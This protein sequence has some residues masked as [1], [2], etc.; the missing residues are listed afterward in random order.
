MIKV[1]IVDDHDLVRAGISSVLAAQD[2]ISVVGEACSGEEALRMCRELSPDVVLMDVRMPGIGGL[3]ATTK[4]AVQHPLIKV[5]IITVCED[6]LMP[7]R[8]LQA[9]ASG[10]ITKGAS[11]EEMVKAI[12]SVHRGDPYISGHLAQQMA[13]Q[14]LRPQTE[15]SPFEGL[16]D[17]EIQV[18]LM[19]TTG[20]KVSEI[21]EVLNLSPKTVNTYRYRIFEK[22]GASSDVELMRLAIRHGLVDA[23]T[24]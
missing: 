16:S 21:S 2:G 23:A 15:S 11:A 5:L 13:F 14:S 18:A 6:D 20:K 1:L 9:G 4:M 8:L 10:Y 24:L 12:R 3:G 7:R 17:R 19:V 22:I